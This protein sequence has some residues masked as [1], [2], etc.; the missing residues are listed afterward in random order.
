MR[1]E[2]ARTELG[3]PASTE[4]LVS[5]DAVTGSRRQRV[6][7]ASRQIPV[8]YVVTLVVGGVALVANAGRTRVPQ[9]RADRAPRR[10]SRRRRGPEPRAP[11][12]PRRTV[13][14]TARRQRP[15]DRCRRS[16]PAERACSDNRSAASGQGTVIAWSRGH[17]AVVRRRSSAPVRPHSSHRSIWRSRSSILLR[18]D[19]GSLLGRLCS[20]GWSPRPRRR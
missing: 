5:L 2:A 8:L 10:R 4:L 14:R 1:A 15:P 13:E 16:R 9:Q 6:A 17:R 18:S 12:R 11:L 20:T 3:T 19:E 7:A